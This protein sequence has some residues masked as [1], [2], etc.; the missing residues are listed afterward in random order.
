MTLL[1]LGLMLMLILVFMLVLVL[2][3]LLPLLLLVLTRSLRAAVDGGARQ[4]QPDALLP[5]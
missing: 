5:H 2:L 4:L 1:V 3:I